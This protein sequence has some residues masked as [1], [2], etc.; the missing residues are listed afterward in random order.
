MEISDRVKEL[1]KT[2]NLSR[3]SF[4]NKLGITKASVSRIENGVFNL[5]SQLSKLI[6][7]E[8]NVRS[9][10][11]STWQWLNVVKCSRRRTR[12]YS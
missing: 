4:G 1:R 11:G 3:R 5:T 2:L 9:R 7:K 10:S 6:C 12:K 8:F